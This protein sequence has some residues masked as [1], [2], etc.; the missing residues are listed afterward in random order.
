MAERSSDSDASLDIHERIQRLRT[1]TEKGKSEHLRLLRNKTIGALSNLTKC[2]NELESLL[3]DNDNLPLVKSCIHKLHDLSSR[4]QTCNEI[5]SSSLD[6]E[7][8]RTAAV[9]HAEAKLQDIKHVHDLAVSWIGKAERELF[10]QVRNQSVCQDS[11]DDKQSQVSSKSQIS[12]VSSTQ[13]AR[14]MEKAKLAELR[15]E[16]AM[17]ETQS[18][19]KQLQLD[20]DIAKATAREKVFADEEE[21]IIRQQHVKFHNPDHDEIHQ[22]LLSSDVKCE[23]N[24]IPN[25]VNLDHSLN[26]NATEYHSYDS[27]RF[28]NHMKGNEHLH[29]VPGYPIFAPSNQFIEAQQQM[30]NAMFLPRSEVSKFTG[31]PTE[32]AAFMMAFDARVVPHT[33]SDADRLYYL[34]Q[35]LQGE[36][37][38]LISGCL[39][40]DVASGY[41]QAR[42]LLFEEYGNPNRVSTAYLN[43]I[44]SCPVLKHDD[45]QGLKQFSFN[46]K[47]CY[48]VMQS[49]SQLLVLN[50]APYLQAIV[51]KLPQH[52]QSKWRDRVTSLTMNGECFNGFKD[53]VDFIEFAAKSANEPT[54]GKQALTASQDL[55]QP[56]NNSS[57]KGKQS[58]SRSQSASFVTQVGHSPDGKVNSPKCFYCKQFHDLDECKHF[59]QKSLVEKRDFLKTCNRCFSC[60]GL[61]HSAKGCMRKKICKTCNK[62]HPTA[63]HDNSYQSSR[64][65]S[66]EV[67]SDKVNEQSNKGLNNSTSCNASK[68]NCIET[69]FQPILPVQVTVKGSNK[70]TTTYAMLDNGST[71]CFMTEDLRNRLDVKSKPATLK[72]QTMNGTEYVNTSVVNG[73]VVSDLDGTNHVSLPGTYSKEVMPVDHAH[74]P[75]P[76]L[77]KQIP[78]LRTVAD[79]LP[80]YMPNLDI[81]ILIGSNCPDALKPLEVVSSNDSGPFAVLHKHGWT[82]NGPMQVRQNIVDNTVV[83]NRIILH[84]VEKSRE[85]IAPETVLKLFE[86]DFSENDLGC[87]PGARGYSIEDQQFM[88]KTVFSILMA[89]SKFHFLSGPD[90]AN[91]LIG[92]LTRFRSESVAFM[93]DVEAMFHQVK[94]PKEQQDFLRFFWWP[95]GNIQGEVKEFRMTVHTFGTISSPT[96]ANYALRESANKAKNRYDND[97]IQTI[98]RNFYVDDCLKSVK[99]DQT[100]VKLIS[101]LQS[102][103]AES[104]FNLTKFTCNS[105]EVL[106]SIPSEHCSKEVQTIDLSYDD[107]PMER[108]LGMQWDVMMD[109]FRFSVNLPHKPPTRRGILSTMSSLYDPLGLVSPILLPAKRILQDLCRDKSLGWDDEVDDGHKLRWEQWLSDFEYLKGLSVKRCLKPIDFGNIISSQLHIFSDA[110]VSGY[111]CAAYLRLCDDK[112]NIYTSLLMGKARLAP[113]KIVTIPRLEL[114]AAVTAVK[115]GQFL[116]KES[117]IDIDSVTYY[118]DSTTVLHY[119]CNERNRYPVFVANRVKM[120]R[121]YASPQQWKYIDTR[122]N[123]ADT[124]SRGLSCK[125]FLKSTAETSGGTLPQILLIPSIKRKNSKAQVSEV[126]DNQRA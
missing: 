73:L 12:H 16:K 86:L 74:I 69:I 21:T 24:I 99:D 19:I 52:L 81:G 57:S 48:H 119:I 109:S 6:T 72:L 70:G 1:M 32:F 71:G 78:H 51:L 35:Q 93:G 15:T 25:L 26:P 62:R 75:K 63:M 31:E 30:V 104:G 77:L 29:S 101:D 49:M 65:A 10:D 4:Y 47:K 66:H 121:D 22:P 39:Y 23:A 9:Q 40:M 42:R 2:K 103:C 13:S 83:C 17:F 44:L 88:E 90:L 115:I 84:E 108:A 3:F 11:A 112:D 53:L 36:P 89:I 87:T 59:K 56:K 68:S 122:Q 126:T 100:A 79:K 7:E 60:Y 117:D 116:L 20:I 46:L 91:S 106:S 110:S 113:L 124:A 98:L 55:L 27:R 82:I 33:N 54:F 123:P 34:D 94:V 92:V 85:C 105:K 97:V 80:T 118:T 5:Y 43:R 111:G 8:A 114:T 76:E 64:N 28:D 120:I 45:F 95:N 41:Q 38:D 14:L 96:I 107:I 18:K 125:L 102:V 37:K 50:H 61:G 67:N 58:S